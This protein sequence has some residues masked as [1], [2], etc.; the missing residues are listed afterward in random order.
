MRMAIEDRR[1]QLPFVA[2][3]LT[4]ALTA[5]LVFAL[6]ASSLSNR[7]AVAVAGR[8]IP[9]GSTI[10]IDDLRAVEMASGQ[11]AGYVPMADVG[12]LVGHTVRAAIPEGAILHPGLLSASSP[13]DQGMAV[14]GA[15]LEPG[16]YP[17]A[18]LGPGQSVGVVV[19][20][21]GRDEFTGRIDGSLGLASPAGA[22]NTAIRA[23]VAE[24]SEVLDSG[25]DALFVSLLT[26]AQDAV[27]IGNAAAFD[28]LRLILLPAEPS[29]DDS[30]AA[31]QPT[32]FG[33][34]R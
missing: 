13:V 19:A 14:V 22:V 10:E 8:N 11:G 4:V 6:W 17:I 24:V 1:R 28:K 32:G 16:E 18:G 26:S 25:K 15:V 9:T 5:A 33:A 2:L 27:L 12:S 31:R 29:P 7:T 30:V 34:S 3:G 21:D 23:T 20:S